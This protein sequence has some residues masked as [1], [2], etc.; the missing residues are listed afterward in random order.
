MQEFKDATAMAQ[1][2][3]NGEV[4]SVELVQD[5]LF[6][7]KQ[8]NPTLNAVVHLQEERALKEAQSSNFRDKP[9]AGVP[10]L[11]KDL[12]QCQKDEPSTA[13]SRLFKN[14]LQQHQD[15]LV[16]KLEEAGFVIIGRTNTPEF[17]FKNMT[18]PS[19]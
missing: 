19:L 15:T 1:A 16:T 2:V 10:L 4:S 5:A 18:E 12:G 8:L 7:V 17:G 6:K 13:G 9:F 3:R 14:L 11:L